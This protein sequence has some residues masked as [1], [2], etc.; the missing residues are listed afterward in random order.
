[1]KRVTVFQMVM[2]LFLC[3]NL[4]VLPGLQAQEAKVAEKE[5]LQAGR[6]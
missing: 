6:D 4:A 1:M 3:M 2:V 5:E